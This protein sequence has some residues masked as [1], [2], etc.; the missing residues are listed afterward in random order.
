MKKLLIGLV[1]FS[2]MFSGFAQSTLHIDTLNNVRE[3]IT[4]PVLNVEEKRLIAEQAQLVLEGI[5]VN[6]YQKMEY[7]DG[8]EDPVSAIGEVVDN[9]DSLSTED[10]EMAIYEIITAQRD[11]HLNYIF[12]DPYSQYSCFIP[13]FFERTKGKGNF[14]EVRIEGVDEGFLTSF[15]PGQRIPEIGD[16]VI[17][18][19]DMPISK[20]VE[21]KMKTSQ[22]ANEYGG[23]KRAIYRMTFIPQR[24]HPLPSEDNVKITLR[25][26]SDGEEYSITIPWITYWYTDD[27]R[28]SVSLQRDKPVSPLKSEPSRNEIQKARKEFI[29]GSDL[30]Q[31]LYNEFKKTMGIETYTVY[32][33]NPSNE[34]TISWGIV[35]DE[36]GHFGYLRLESFSPYLGTM[37]AIN[38]IIRLLTTELKDTEGLIIDVRDNGGGSLL[39]AEALPQLFMPYKAKAVKSRMMN[40]DFIHYLFNE[41]YMHYLYNP[42][43]KDAVNATPDDS[44]YTIPTPFFYD[45]EV[46]TVGQVYYKPVVVLN[47][48]AS[49][50]A[51][52]V[53]SCVM[54]DNYFPVLGEDY[55]T[56][57]GGANVLTYSSIAE[58][59]GAPFA[60]LPYNHDMRYSFSQVL[61][62]GK[63]NG[64]VIEDYGC[65]PTKVVSPVVEDLLD[66]GVAQQ[67]LVTSYLAG[68]KD[69]YKTTVVPL[70][71]DTMLFFPAD[72]LEFGVTVT[73][74]KHIVVKTDGKLSDKIYIA[75]PA[76]PLYV[77]I[78]LPQNL[79]VGDRFD[80]SLYGQAVPGARS[81][82]MKKTFVITRDKLVLTS[83]GFEL[84]FSTAANLEPFTIMNIGTAPENGWVLRDGAMTVGYNPEYVDNVHTEAILLVDASS[85]T[86]GVFSFTMEMETEE[87]YD[88]FQVVAND[89][90]RDY[91]LFFDSGTYATDTYE[92]DMADLPPGADISN[93]RLHFIF[94]S[95][96]MITDKGVRITSLSLK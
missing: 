96:V 48:A 35:D 37:G 38:E 8:H 79:S 30:W 31:Q 70:H 23:F 11:L 13:V 68:W 21:E 82:N 19:N 89:G 7:Y 80:I 65:E 5:Y 52:D 87:Y 67:N 74:T 62:F 16:E 66:G 43:W 34:A 53:F 22:G 46:N 18:Y 71:K 12:P 94:T 56:G 26:Y 49:Y 24:L 17:A 51:T 41:T 55:T 40:T 90:Q 10:M 15:A 83:E 39:Y 6:R 25:S 84:D 2:L 33:E 57:A 88:F 78:T 72:K 76:E 77:P 91:T 1:F 14:F 27:T 3:S 4:F 36:N 20:A 75:N 63:N 95:D 45:Y 61:R 50:S 47:N 29:Q 32:P 28:A 42:E 85:M 9:I 60:E 59:I 81:W 44:M 93:M 64:K 69:R 73:N 86:S 58:F 54:R 92:F